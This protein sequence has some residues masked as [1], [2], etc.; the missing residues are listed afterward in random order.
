[1]R[2]FG[3]ALRY[4]QGKFLSIRAFLGNFFK[5]SA[6]DFWWRIFRCSEIC[7]WVLE[8]GFLEFGMLKG[9]SPGQKLDT[10]NPRWAYLLAVR[11]IE[12]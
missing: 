4:K 1:M 3:I 6:L 5:K 7:G 11:P 2:V 10:P 9:L 12:C 8:V